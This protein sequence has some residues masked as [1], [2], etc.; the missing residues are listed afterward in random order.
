M[1]SRYKQL[2]IGRSQ[3]GASLVELSIST[4]IMSF[5]SVVVF[6]LLISTMAAGNKLNN[7]CD[8][9]DVSRTALERIS[10]N[11]RTGRSLGDVFGTQILGMVQGSSLFPSNRNPVYG[12][13]QSPPDGWPTWADGRA[14]S[15]FV[16]D[17]RTLVVQVP[18]FDPNGFPTAIPPFTGSPASDRVQDNVETHIYRVIPDPSIPGEWIMQWARIPGMAAA[19]Y[20]PADEQTAP[21][22]ICT[23]IVGPMQGGQPCV[24]Q[25]IDKTDATGTPQNVIPNGGREIAAFS[26]LIVNL[27]LTHHQNSSQV[28]GTWKAPGVL[29]LK[30]EVFLRNN[31]LATTVGMPSTAVAP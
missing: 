17:N 12:A 6:S 31:S 15:S 22:T 4:V 27:E 5:T 18:I 21:Q 10:K 7:K 16:V 24:F 14:P 1:N 28:A 30:T 9:I 19:G 13:G 25:Y 23:G 26:G 3:T 8:T 29:A 11:V 20:V 2:S